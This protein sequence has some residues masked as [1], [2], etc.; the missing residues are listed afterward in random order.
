MKKNSTKIDF[1]KKRKRRVS[2]KIAAIIIL[3]VLCLGS[4]LISFC[5]GKTVLSKMKIRGMSFQ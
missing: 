5:I 3:L 2:K 4:L 1:P